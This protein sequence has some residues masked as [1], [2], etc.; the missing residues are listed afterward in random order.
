[1]P[2]RENQP[3]P[4]MQAALVGL[5]EGDKEQAAYLQK[6]RQL[7]CP[8]RVVAMVERH[9]YDQTDTWNRPSAS[10]KANLNS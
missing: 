3:D 4:R 6:L 7:G 9:W 2:N 5:E 8:D 10:F 1:M